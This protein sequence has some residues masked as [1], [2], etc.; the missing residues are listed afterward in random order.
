MLTYNYPCMT[1]AQI[2]LGGTVMLLSLILIH[3]TPLFSSSELFSGSKPI[4][5]YES[6]QNEQ[7]RPT[8]SS[9]TTYEDSNYGIGMSY[10]TD[11]VKR[12]TYRNYDNSTLVL[13][14][15]PPNTLKASA[16]ANDT[17]YRGFATEVG[18]WISDLF[19][20]EQSLDE[21]L[22]DL[23]DN[24][25]ETR[26]DNKVLGSDTNDTLGG[27]PAYYLVEENKEGW[28]TKNMMVGTI[29]DDNKILEIEYIA[30]PQDYDRYLPIV[31]Q[32][33]SSFRFTG[34]QLSSGEESLGEQNEDE[35]EEEGAG[36]SE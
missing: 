30:M 26:A 31:N 12:G 29:I 9:F 6:Y 10:P 18:L 7:V 15:A 16:V 25:N 33:M 19:E 8:T 5:A 24:H 17:G 32:I 11:W 28:E 36:E 21:Y 4:G 27:R 35:N 3:P 20:D 22:S 1:W 23:I 34:D 14:V 2:S 13:A